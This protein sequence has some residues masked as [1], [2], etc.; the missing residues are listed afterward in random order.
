MK[1]LL[2]VLALFFLLSTSAFADKFI[3]PF[4]C[5]P[6]KVQARF[7]EHNLKLDLDPNERTEDS[8]GFLRN[9]G[10]QYSII[11]YHSITEKEFELIMF[12]CNRED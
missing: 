9:E 12:L 8:W 1:K 7:A 6:K 4:S 2:V 10:T 5:Y 3:I 11:T